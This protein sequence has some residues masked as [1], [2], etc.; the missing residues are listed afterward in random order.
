MNKPPA[1]LGIPI[2][3]E[4]ITPPE[5]EVEQLSPPVENV[6]PPAYAPAAD[7]AARESGGPIDGWLDG[8]WTRV[9]QKIRE[10]VLAQVLERVDTMIDQRIREGVADVLQTA[11]GRLTDDLRIGLHQTLDDII[12]DAVAQEIERTRFTKN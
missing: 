7:T 2:L 10:R 8:E 4:V 1:D 5:P 3:T 11:I 9:E 12:T 6:A